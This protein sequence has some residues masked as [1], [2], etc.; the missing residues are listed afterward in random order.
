METL[1]VLLFGLSGLVLSISSVNA[2]SIQEC[3][4][5]LITACGVAV[6]K[7][8]CVNHQVSAATKADESDDPSHDPNVKDSNLKTDKDYH[9]ESQEQ[10]YDRSSDNLGSKLSIC[11]RS[12]KNEVSLLVSNDGWMSGHSKHALDTI[13]RCSDFDDEEI[14]DRGKPELDQNHKLSISNEGYEMGLTTTQIACLKG[15]PDKSFTINGVTYNGADLNSCD[16]TISLQPE[17]HLPSR[18]GVRTLH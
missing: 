4:G 3:K 14:Q 17:S 12:C 11:H 9:E 18:G 2:A 13:G 7:T 16:F 8:T 1:A 5:E 15:S 6:V 10:H